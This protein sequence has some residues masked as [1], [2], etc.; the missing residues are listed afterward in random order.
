M[1]DYSSVKNTAK[2]GKLIRAEI[3]EY[4]LAITLIYGFYR[5]NEL[6]NK[7]YHG[8]LHRINQCVFTSI[9]PID[10]NL[11]LNQIDDENLSLI[12]TNIAN[13]MKYY[14]KYWLEN[15][16]M[17]FYDTKKFRIYYNRLKYG[18]DHKINL[19]K[20]RQYLWTPVLL[21]CIVAHKYRKNSNEI[22]LKD[23]WFY[24]NAYDKH[25]T[26]SFFIDYLKN[27]C[28]IKSKILYNSNEDYIY[29]EDI[30]EVI[31]LAI[32]NAAFI[33]SKLIEGNYIGEKKWPEKK[34]KK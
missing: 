2:N 4:V 8:N 31:N 5:D 15:N 20:T 27:T 21:T 11:I 33:K 22:S 23:L 13:T 26:M 3:R 28:K 29:F 24:D 6:A 32:K 9:C 30:Q 1:T 7:I 18:R 17:I 19:A 16:N 10:R 25:S 14:F 12:Q 34:K